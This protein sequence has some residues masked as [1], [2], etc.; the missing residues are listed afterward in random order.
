MSALTLI[1]SA[2]TA[3]TQDQRRINTLRTL[4]QPIIDHLAEPDVEDLAVNTDG[5]LWIKH[6]GAGFQ[7]HG[8]FSK[9]TT[10]S[11]LSQ[12]AS[13][14]RLLFSESTPVL[15]T[16]FPLDG[17][18]ITGLRSPIVDGAA[19]AF[20]SHPKRLYTLADYE[21]AG[22]ITAKTD[23]INRLLRRDTFKEEAQG[24]SHADVFRLAIQ[25]KKNIVMVGST[26]SGKTTALNMLAHE[27]SC[28]FPLDRVVLIEDTREVQLRG[29][30]NCVSLLAAG[31]I[32][33]A[34][35][36][37][38]SLRLNPDRIFVG[39]VRDQVAR[40]LI[41]AWN[42]GHRGGI[43][44]VHADNAFAGLQRFEEML[45]G[46]ARDNRSSI[47][48]AVNLVIFIDEEPGIAA[49]RK[50]REVLLLDGYDSQSDKYLFTYL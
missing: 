49:G 25:H 44:T 45:P 27:I 43:A 50:I 42:T 16:D 31:R 20:R 6:K 14:K 30:Q 36:L 29:M 3:E 41:D 13:L 40:T 19:M 2:H 26:G 9:H 11:M 12:V 21:S 32:S 17:S 39:E 7:K 4:S 47:S 48:R 24:K 18:R 37:K 8:T 15:E 33:F 1:H 22:I 34:K 35:C 23:P 38:V 10:L 46:R 28:Q 5:C